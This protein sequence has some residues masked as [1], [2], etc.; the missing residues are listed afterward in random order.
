[1]SVCQKLGIGHNWEIIPDYSPTS[2]PG[3]IKRCITCGQSYAMHKRKAE[4]QGG[5]PIPKRAMV[6]ATSSAKAVPVN[7]IYQ[8]FGSVQGGTKAAIAKFTTQAWRG[9]GEEIKTLDTP[10]TAAYTAAYT[11]DTNPAH[12]LN[13]NSNTAS[14]QCVN[15]AQQGTGI[16]QRLGNK[17]SMKSLRIRFNLYANSNQFSFPNPVRFMVLYDR[18]VNG[19]Y[20]AAN[21]ILSQSLQQNTIASGSAFDH[22]NPTF[23]DRF[24]TLLDEYIITPPVL[25]DISAASTDTATEVTNF[26]IDRYINLKNLE[27]VFSNTMS[28]M[29]VAQIQ[30]GALMILTYSTIAPGNDVWCFQGTTR[31]R[32]RDN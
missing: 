8:R 16:G 10:F 19:T 28:P 25:L 32:F 6:Y 30:T 4:F 7:R 23:F 13:Q 11:A 27:T 29:T 15:L 14:V 24:V 26:I 22:L 1:M 2:I 31:L 20:T 5:R 3:Y 21:S 18:N 12:M 17:I 9:R